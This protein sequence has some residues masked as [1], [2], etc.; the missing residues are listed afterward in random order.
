[1]I[2]LTINSTTLIPKC[3]STMVLNPMLAFPNHDKISGNGA[4]MMNST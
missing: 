3:S 4:L 1:M 2:R